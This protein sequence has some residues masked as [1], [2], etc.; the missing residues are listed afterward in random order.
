MAAG[1]VLLVTLI[2]AAA[3]IL[4]WGGPLDAVTHDFIAQL[5]MEVRQD[6]CGGFFEPEF[7]VLPL[8]PDACDLL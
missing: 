4:V 1:R 3:G 5:R 6:S 7:A 8:T 2:L